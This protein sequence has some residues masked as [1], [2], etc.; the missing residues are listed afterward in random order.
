MTAKMKR[1]DFITLLGGAAVAWPLAARA[2]QPAM[3]VIGFLN[4]VSPE[5]FAGRLQGFHR[6]LKDAGYVEGENVAIVYR[7]AE[8]Q[9]DRLPELAADLVRRQV[10]VIAATGGPASALAAK[11]ATTT[12]PIVFGV[13]EDPVNLGLVASL[14]RPGGNLTGINFFT[15]ELGAKQLGLLRELVPS[16]T[17]IAVLVNPANVQAAARAVAEVEAA[18]PT[19]GLQIQVFNAS[20]GREINGAL[21]A[22]ARERADALFISGDPY[23]T[24]RRV[25]LANLAARYAIPASFVARDFPQAGGLMSY[26]TNI[27]D[28]YRQIGIYAGRILKGAKPADLPIVQASKF[29]L[30]INLA[31]A[32]MLGLEVPPTLLARADEVIE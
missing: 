9:A 1:R 11:L 28:G 10:A 32:R 3:P 6:G 2:Q 25:Q 8:N 17:R 7:W 21:A 14:A 31:T 16:A 18:A 26:G 29:E 4:V 5:M 19:M 13:P 27:T 22:V 30:V 23:F 24:V 15:G 12:I 20:T